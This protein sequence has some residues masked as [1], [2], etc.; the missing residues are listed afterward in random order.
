MHSNLMKCL[1]LMQ[2]IL[3]VLATLGAL[4][5]TLLYDQGNNSLHCNIIKAKVSSVFSHILILKVKLLHTNK[6]K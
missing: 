6:N 2:F 3:F 4:E 5:F 1:C